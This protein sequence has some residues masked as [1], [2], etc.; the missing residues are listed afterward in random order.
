MPGTHLRYEIESESLTKISRICVLCWGLIGDVF[1]RIPVIEA[2]RVRFPEANIVAVVDP[3][4]EVVLKNHPAVNEVYVFSRHK[5]PWWRYVYRTVGCSHYLRRKNFDLSVNLY[6]GGSSPLI[7][8]IINARIRL[9]FDHT[10]ALRKANNLLVPHPNLCTE[11]AKGFGSV[12]TPLGVAREQIRQGTTY[13]VAVTGKQFAANFLGQTAQQHVVINLGAR[14]AEKRWP[15]KAFV[16]LAH[17][18]QQQFQLLPVILTNP[19]MTEL[20]A[21]FERLYKH[22]G[23]YRIVPLSSLDDVAGVMAASPFVVTGDTSIMHLSFGLK[24]PTLVLFTFTR[25]D[26]VAPEDCLHRYCF[27]PD[28]SQT[29][30]CGNPMGSAAIPVPLV[31]EI[32]RISE[33][34]L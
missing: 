10:K 13:H 27:I 18:I 26:V 5:Q 15:V 17:H 14:V 11:W 29:D 3:A 7:S 24:C 30:A 33:G 4:A 23:D 22:K 28:S 32:C 6:S 31:R 21:E 25:P 16:E 34:I 12:L 2:L 19:G 8:R 20:T 9:G 1:V